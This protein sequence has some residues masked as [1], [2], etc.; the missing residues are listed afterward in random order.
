MQKTKKK[1]KVCFVITSEIHYARN[2]LV[3]EALRAR[4][5]VDL[6]I[7]VGASAI[8]PVHGN[9]PLLFPKALVPFG[10]RRS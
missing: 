6:R 8:L 10:N 9:V 4:K 1:R 7:V 5:D 3:L 2:K